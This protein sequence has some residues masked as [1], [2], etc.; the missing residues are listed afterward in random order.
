[1][2]LPPFPVDDMTLSVVYDSLD[3]VFDCVP[4]SEP[5]SV[6]GPG[7]GLWDVLNHLSGFDPSRLVQAVNE[8]DQPIPDMYHYPDPTYSPEDVIRALIDE[9]RALRAGAPTIRP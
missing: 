2:T 6:S 1:M 3:Q 7:F 8:Y 5:V 9:I 4:G